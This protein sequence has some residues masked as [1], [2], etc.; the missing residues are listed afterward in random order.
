MWLCISPLCY[1]DNFVPL[2]KQPKTCSVCDHKR[3]S[4]FSVPSDDEVEGSD[5]GV[6]DMGTR[7]YIERLQNSVAESA[8][9]EA[10]AE[11]RSGFRPKQ[12]ANRKVLPF[13]LSIL[14]G[15]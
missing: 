2:K 11:T 5:D 1:C 9:V 7:P 12:V 15:T 8:V 13:P 14:T 10:I 3:S 6:N 4:H